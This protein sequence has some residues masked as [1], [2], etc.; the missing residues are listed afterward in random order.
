MPDLYRV[1]SWTA[2][3]LGLFFVTAFLVATVAYAFFRPEFYLEI[4]KEHFAATVGLATITLT[5][6]F[7]VKVFR[8]SSGEIKLR[9]FGIEL[10]GSSGE[11]VLFAVVFLVKTFAIYLLW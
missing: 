8:L 4:A 3:I 6:T 7:V 5:S 9:G 2:F 11:V 1:T 10:S